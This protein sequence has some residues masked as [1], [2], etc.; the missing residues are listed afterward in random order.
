[1]ATGHVKNVATPSGG[2]GPNMFVEPTKALGAFD[3]ELP[4]GVGTRNPV[5]GDGVFNIDTSLAKRFTMP[6][7]EKHTL[8]FRWETF[9]LT[10]TA[11][12]DVYTA[13]LDIAAS[14]TFGAY[15]DMLTQPRVMQFSLRYQF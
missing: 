13:S 14:G 9:N 10:N 5:R 3:F 11:K 6:W 7:S 12:F 8:Q 4:G 15:Q 1:V 2:S